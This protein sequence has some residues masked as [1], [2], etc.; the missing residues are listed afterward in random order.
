MQTYRFE[1]RAGEEAALDDNR[2][3]WEHAL[4]FVKRLPAL[5]G[6]LRVID[7]AGMNIVDL[8]LT[9]CAG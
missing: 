7:A 6:R 9:P 5:E 1:V 8:R 2:A 3:A 4:R